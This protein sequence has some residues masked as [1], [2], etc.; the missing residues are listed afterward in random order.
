MANAMTDYLSYIDIGI[1][2]RKS[3]RERFIHNL[4]LQKGQFAFLE[5]LHSREE[6]VCL[7]PSTQAKKR[8]AKSVACKVEKLREC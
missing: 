8:V 7:S 3:A 4:A 1:W 2:R 5:L 6:C